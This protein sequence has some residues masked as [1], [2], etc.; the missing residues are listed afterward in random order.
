MARPEPNAPLPV[1]GS[2]SETVEGKPLGAE[3]TAPVKEFAVRESP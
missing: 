3:A 1:E 2:V